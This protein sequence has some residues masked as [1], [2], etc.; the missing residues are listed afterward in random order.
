ML[1][2]AK[3]KQVISSLSGNVLKYNGKNKHLLSANSEGE[4]FTIL[5]SFKVYCL[6]SKAETNTEHEI[7]LHILADVI[8]DMPK[9][10]ATLVWRTYPEYETQEDFKTGIKMHRVYLRLGWE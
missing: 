5:P 7:C 6:G 2:A 9:K 8:H 4:A 3:L 10:P 1:N